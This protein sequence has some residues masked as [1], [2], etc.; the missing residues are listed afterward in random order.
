MKIIIVGC[1]KVGFTLAQQLNDEG[2][3][4]TLIDT[5]ES[6]LEKALSQL[7]VFAVAGN[8]TTFR[9]QQEAGIKKSD[10]LIAVTGK[11]EVNLLCCLIAK[12]SGNCNTIARVRNPEYFEEIG[13]LREELGLSLA[14]NPE[15]ACARSIANLIEVPSVLD[16]TSF[17]KGRINMIQ[18]QI[19]EGSLVNEMSVYEFANKVHNNTLIC[20]IE[21]AHEVLIP[22][23]NTTI[24]AGDLMYVIM[25]PS[26]IHHLLAKIGIKSK[27]IKSVMIIG[28]SMISYYLAAKL[29]AAHIQVKIIEQNFE[30]CERLSEALPHAMIIHGDASDR[31][32]LLEEGIEDMDA[33]ISLTNLDEENLIL[34]LFASKVSDAKKITKVDKVAFSEVV[35][36]LPIG[37]IACPKNITA[38]TIIQYIRALQNSYG[39]NIETLYRMLDDRVE[40]LEFAIRQ[41]S[42]VTNKPL[43]ELKLK[44]NLLV[45]AI[46][47]GKEIITP[48]G[49][50]QIM[51]GDTVIVVTTNKGL[52][53][54]KDILA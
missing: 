27:P 16:I 32:L 10:L 3:D 20:A 43:T 21:R 19:P 51:Q 31:Q 30:Q 52:T 35:D 23:G 9:T 28:G 34:S 14:V 40:A 48:S 53:D 37:T 42:K 7:D 6:K 4:I 13:Y 25:P 45:C 49:K 47:R 41:E 38:K 24:K 18:I 44:K 26:E 12:K 54:I 15:Y 2:H 46:I 50:D 22:D 33:F 29:R 1:G 17:A 39:S 36:E 8:G 5:N 11:D